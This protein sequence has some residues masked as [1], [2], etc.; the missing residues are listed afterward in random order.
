MAPLWLTAGYQ[1]VGELLAHPEE[2][3]P[4]RI[5][6]LLTDLEGAPLTLAEKFTAFL[7][8]DRGASADEY[9]PVLELSPLCPLYLGHYL[10]EEP[11]TCRDVGCS[12][13]NA[14]MLELTGIY[15]HFGLNLMGREL[16]DFLPV[17]TDFLRL[18][19][20]RPDRDRT[21]LREH[22]IRHYVWPALPPLAESLEKCETPYRELVAALKILLGEEL[23]FKPSREGARGRGYHP[24]PIAGTA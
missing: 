1:L 7:E 11:S 17:V 23:K 2:R 16:P 6:G 20:A 8:D 5:A 15:Q 21:G 24:L 14:Y 13:R 18:S 10:Y 19:L 9:V 22:F 12:G 4:Q 3:D